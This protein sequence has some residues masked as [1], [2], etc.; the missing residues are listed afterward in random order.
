M[1][2]IKWKCKNWI[3]YFNQFDNFHLIHLIIEKLDVFNFHPIF[4]YCYFTN[5]TVTWE[6]WTRF[7]KNIHQ[8]LKYYWEEKQDFER[9]LICLNI[10]MSAKSNKIK[11]SEEFM[12]MWKEEQ[13]PEVFFKRGVINNFA[14]FTGKHQH[15]RQSLFLKLQASQ[16]F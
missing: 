9:F 10:K 6:N 7:L 12:V 2:L 11:P 15:L 8:K 13:P 16:N 4:Y 1:D 14:K 3:V 5:F